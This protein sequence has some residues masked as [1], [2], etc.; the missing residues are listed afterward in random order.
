MV[1]DLNNP[2]STGSSQR[3]P[4]ARQG[5]DGFWPVNQP[6]D[7]R[8]IIL[9]AS[10]EPLTD[11]EALAPEH[12]DGVSEV[13][14]LR[15]PAEPVL[16]SLVARASS[17]ETAENLAPFAFDWEALDA[18]TDIEVH[19]F[20][21]QPLSGPIS[22]WRADSDATD[23]VGQNH[24]QI[25]GHVGFVPGRFGQA[26]RF[27]GEGDF[28]DVG[29]DASL[30]PGLGS[31]SISAWARTES[32]G[33]GRA[34]IFG[35]TWAGRTGIWM[36]L[37]KEGWPEFLGLFRNEGGQI[38]SEIEVRNG[39]WHHW[40]GVIDVEKPEILLYIDGEEVASGRYQPVL[41]DSLSDPA[42]LKTNFRIGASQAPD[43]VG[44]SVDPWLGEID[45]L[46]TSTR[47]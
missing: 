41:L 28:V 10:S 20:P 13:V 8:D 2:L 43:W 7:W 44:G 27:D 23:S 32:D 9:L 4:G 46:L 17:T 39:F 22:W 29:A 3:L 42:S 5:Y 24:G 36:G 6:E 30:Q 45:D 47:L 25:G 14:P 31:F 35:H 21:L 1:F 38:N 33:E 26:F 34:T 15:S 11:I 12:P 18:R 40:V 19:H 16:G 37:D